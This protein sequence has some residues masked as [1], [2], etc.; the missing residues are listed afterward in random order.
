MSI[1]QDVVLRWHGADYPVPS[2][3]VMKMIAAVES[4]ITLKELTQDRGVPLARM[5]AGYSAALTFAGARVSP[6][7]VY[8]ELFANGSSDIPMLISALLSM[9]IPPAVTATETKKPAKKR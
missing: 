1:F 4:E 7:D 3:R 8:A 9:M 2:N 5:A 6:E